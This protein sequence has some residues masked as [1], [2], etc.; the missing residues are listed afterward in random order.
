METVRKLIEQLPGLKNVSLSLY[1]I[2][3]AKGIVKAS[4]FA[5]SIKQRALDNYLK[6]VAAVASEMLA[7]YE[8][9]VRYQGDDSEYKMQ[10]I[11]TDSPMVDSVWTAIKGARKI[12]ES[13]WIS[14]LDVASREPKGVWLKFTYEGEPVEMF[15]DTPPIKHLKGPLFLLV[16]N[17]FDVVEGPVLVLPLKVDL[18][19]FKGRLYFLSKRG[20][21]M[22]ISPEAVVE[23]TESAVA[24]MTKTGAISNPDEFRQFAKSGHNPRRLLRFDQ[25]RF[26]RLSDMVNG[27]DIREKFGLSFT[28]GKLVVDTK[29]EAEKLIK[30]V[31]NRGMVDPFTEGAMEVTGAEKWK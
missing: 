22:C 27:K 17:K 10:W 29:S 1:R 15:F 8:A 6:D 31:C 28:D 16:N 7:D 5:M 4:T 26:D 12:A 24:T 19:S 14:E 11:S 2:N 25:A 30:V 23:H 20:L 21:N 18:I 9:V 3:K 13:D